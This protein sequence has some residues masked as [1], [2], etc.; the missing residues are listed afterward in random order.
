[1]LR[2][3]EVLERLKGAAPPAG[4][5]APILV[6]LGTLLQR[7]RLNSY[8]SAEL[9]RW[10]RG[11]GTQGGGVERL[12]PALL[13]CAVGL[14]HVVLQ[15]V[16]VPG[17]A[18]VAVRLRLL[19]TLRPASCRRMVISQS[20]KELLVNWWGEGK[21]EASEEL[22]DLISAAGEAQTVHAGAAAPQE[23]W[24]SQPPGSQAFDPLAGKALPACWLAQACSLRQPSAS[25]WRPRPRSHGP[26]PLPL[27]VTR[28]WRSRCSSR[29]APAAR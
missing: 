19:L 3:R 26:P 15:Y 16:R 10:G 1:M 18:R 24:G 20:K 17:P 21:L 23:A 9:A 8:E 11:L 12:R 27:Q 7:G 29:A 14:E 5:K 22:G 4:Q 28:T 25:C 2:T 6:Y 13:L